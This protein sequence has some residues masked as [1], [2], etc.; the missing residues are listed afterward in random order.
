MGLGSVGLGVIDGAREAHM[1]GTVDMT[2]VVDPSVGVV[3]QAGGVVE[4]RAARHTAPN[5]VLVCLLAY[6]ARMHTCGEQRDKF[7]IF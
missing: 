5:S 6:K 1:H 3:S 4:P 2:L 7:S